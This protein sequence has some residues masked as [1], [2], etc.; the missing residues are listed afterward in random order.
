MLPKLSLSFTETQRFSQRW[1]WLLAALTLLALG[2][3]GIAMLKAPS[4]PALLIMAVVLLPLLAG[5]WLMRLEV[6]VDAAGIHY[7]YLPLLWRWRYWPW[8]DFQKVFPRTYSPLGEYGGWGIKGLPGEL[9]YNVWGPAGLQLVFQSG[10]RLLLGT[11]QPEQLRLVLASLQA[12]D[13]TRPIALSQPP[14]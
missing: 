10:N 2:S 4:W 14:G 12:A 3:S 13:P 5:L 7:R 8:T 9:V 11:Q 6:R 1:R